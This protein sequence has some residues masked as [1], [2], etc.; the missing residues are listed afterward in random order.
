M[1]IYT[2]TFLD[3]VTQDSVSELLSNTLYN[4]TVEAT[5]PLGSQNSTSQHFFTTPKGYSFLC[6]IV[7]NIVL[8]C[9]TFA[10]LLLQLLY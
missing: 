9:D 2:E 4:V 5:G 8:L 10:C 7:P 3:N 1:K 6:M